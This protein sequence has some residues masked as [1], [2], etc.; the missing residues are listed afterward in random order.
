MSYSYLKKN[1]VNNTLREPSLA[2]MG[3]IVWFHLYKCQNQTTYLIVFWGGYLWLNY[4]LITMK[5]QIGGR[6]F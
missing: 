6:S 3:H 5:I 1:I 4:E 2:Q